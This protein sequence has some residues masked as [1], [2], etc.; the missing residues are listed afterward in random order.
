VW[1]VRRR[2]ETNVADGNCLTHGKNRLT[3]KPVCAF[4]PDT[5]AA[6]DLQ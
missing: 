1:T 2:F 3:K 4:P 5:G 6:F